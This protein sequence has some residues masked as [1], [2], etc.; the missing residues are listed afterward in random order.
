MPLPKPLIQKSYASFLSQ[1]PI[2][3]P[4]AIPPPTW[5]DGKLSLKFPSQMVN[6]SKE[7]FSFS[8]IGKFVGRRPSLE[9][10]EHWVQSSWRLSRPCLISLTEKGFFLFR[11]NSPEDRDIL[12]SQSP[13][14]L[15]RK[16]LMLQS[17][18]PGQNE[19]SWLVITPIW[20]HLKGV[21]Y[22]CW[23]SDILLSIASSVG[24]PLR[25]DETTAK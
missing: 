13:L 8:A 1:L 16:K 7:S 18:T 10:L 17:W 21:P 5:I 12:I 9:A 6:N 14:M 3:I 4:P 15:D 25:L 24:K 11:F 19:E 2:S 22:H 23:S 20:I